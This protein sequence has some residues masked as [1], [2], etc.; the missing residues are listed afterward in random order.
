MIKVATQNS[1]QSDDLQKQEEEKRI[2]L[3]NMSI[4]VNQLRENYSS[5]EELISKKKRW[6]L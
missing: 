2:L 5:L 4:E 6:G 1:N 3:R